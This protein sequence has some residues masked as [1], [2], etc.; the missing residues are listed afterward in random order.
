MQIKPINADLAVSPQIAAEDIPAI[1]EAGF[2]SILCNRPDREDADQ[3]GFDLIEQAARAAGLEVRWQPVISGQVQDADAEAFAEMLDSLPAPVLAYCRSG[4]R[5]AMLWALSQ[6][7]KRPVSDI[8]DATGRAGYDLAALGP[9][10]NA[11]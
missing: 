5:C 10:L 7:G 1:A 3:P 4:T 8:L 11:R 9:R 2:R 6:A